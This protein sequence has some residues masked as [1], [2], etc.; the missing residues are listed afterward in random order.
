ML[1]KWINEVLGILTEFTV[2]SSQFPFAAL[3]CA[4]F[5]IITIE[6]TEISQAKFLSSFVQSLSP[7]FLQACRT[8]LCMLPYLTLPLLC[9]YIP[10]LF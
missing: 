7:V 10:I 1:L 8:L 9:R 6:V 2:V 5:T 4:L 3:L